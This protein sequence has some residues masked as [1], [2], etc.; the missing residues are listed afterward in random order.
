MGTDEQTC[1]GSFFLGTACGY[2]ARCKDDLA[3]AYPAK[4]ELTRLRARVAE[5]EGG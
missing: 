5:L 3:K 2:C 1:R 4:D